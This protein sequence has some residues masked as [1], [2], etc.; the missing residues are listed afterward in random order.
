[1]IGE[2]SNL[3]IRAPIVPR[4]RVYCTVE[5][6]VDWKFWNKATTPAPGTSEW[7]TDTYEA[8]RLLLG[9]LM[10]ADTPPFSSWNAPGVEFA[11][12]LENPAQ[13]ATKGYQLALWFWVFAEKHG[14]VAARMARACS[15]SAFGS[16]KSR[17]TLPLPRI[18]SKSSSLIIAPPSVV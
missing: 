15:R 4:K 13:S 14:V 12:N 9:M 16:P 18:N 1:M 8:V 6:I 7:P 3:H 17:N 11:P 10:R 5:E 2:T